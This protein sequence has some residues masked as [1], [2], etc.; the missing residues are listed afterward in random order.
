MLQCGSEAI[1]EGA[2]G[3][4]FDTQSACYGVEHEDRVSQGRQR[5]EERTVSELVRQVSCYL[6]SQM[7]F[8]H[9]ARPGEGEQVTG[10]V[11][12]QSLH[13]GQV[14]LSS[15]RC[16]RLA[17]RLGKLAEVSGV[18]VCRLSRCEFACIARW[19]L[20]RLLSQ[21][22]REGA[23]AGVVLGCGGIG[24]ALV[25]Q[26]QHKLTVGVLP[27]GSISQQTFEITGPGSIFATRNM[28]DGKPMQGIEQHLPQVFALPTCPLL[29]FGGVAHVEAVEKIARVHVCG[30]AQ[31]AVHAYPGGFR[32]LNKVEEL[33]GIEAVRGSSGR[34]RQWWRVT[35]RWGPPASAGWRE[36]GA[37]RGPH[38]PRAYP[39]E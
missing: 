8:A 36:P 14:G 2:A 4:L 28:V 25:C 3:R 23:A 19:S 12:E 31:P 18:R 7:G 16:G 13:I 20:P 22:V 34:K 21:V 33:L 9:A 1:L 38:A 10:W 39:P 6:Q 11:F 29:E 26:Q 32:M 37:V 15:Y 24:A 5:D 17:G 27:P 35:A 30:F